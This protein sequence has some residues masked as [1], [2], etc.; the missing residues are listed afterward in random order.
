M[1][2][3]SAVVTA[4]VTEDTFSDKLLHIKNSGITVIRISPSGEHIAIGF[5][6][7]D[8][9]IWDTETKV[10]KRILRGHI[11]SITDVAFSPD[12]RKLVSAARDDRIVIWDLTSGRKIISFKVGRSEERI[13]WSPDGTLFATVAG[14]ESESV[15]LW[16]A[17][18]PRL[19]AET[20]KRPG[21]VLSILFSPDSER[22]VTATTKGRAHVWNRWAAAVC[23]LSEHRG[24]I[25]TIAYAPDGKRLI[26]GSVD[27]TCSVW[28]A[29]NGVEFMILSDG[30]GGDS[31]TVWAA[32][33]S[34]DGKR[35]HY[36]G[37]GGI[38]ETYD[39][40]SA[41][42]R[43]RIDCG[44][45]AARTWAFSADGRLFAASS[46][47][48]V[49][50]VWDVE[51]GEELDRLKGHKSAVGYISFSRDNRMLAS[52]SREDGIV[53]KYELTEVL[54]LPSPRACRSA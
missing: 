21:K 17:E 44:D 23:E 54:A 6:D 29:L 26:T 12:G 8:I 10:V 5:S 14:D 3:G 11:E 35:L 19:R 52:V 50:T 53:I 15:K 27:G 51:T 2:D 48:H 47:D 45:K 49:I 43:G 20:G 30:S 37:N 46:E 24:P 32:T 28:S 16:A 7:N 36:I 13:A 4:T 40:Y 34:A 41:E 31:P 38:L 33:F 25:C 39:S 9:A 42:R 18:P 1:E 22:F